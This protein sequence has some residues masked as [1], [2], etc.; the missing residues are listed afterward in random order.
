MPREGLDRTTARAASSGVVWWRNPTI[1]GVLAQALVVVLL[2]AVVWYLVHN[3][4]TNLNERSIRTG[5]SFLDQEAGFAIGESL[6]AFAP[7]DTYGRAL[8]V[9]LLNTLRVSIIGIVLATLIGVVVGIARLS[10]N[11]LVARLASVYVEVTRNIPLLLQLF[12]WYT[13]VTQLLPAVREALEPLPGVVLSKSGLQFPIIV[14]DPAHLP[15]LGV[16]ALSVVAAFV[17]RHRAYR[18]QLETGQEPR[19][20][21]PMLAIICLPALAVFLVTGA[22]LDLDV[23]EF[24]R[25][26]YRGGASVTPEF[27]ALLLGLSIY[28]AGFIAEIV[29]S[30]ILAVPWGQTEAAAALGFRRSLQ[31]R[32]IVLPQALRIIVPPTTSNYLNLTKNSSLAV[33]IGYPDLVSVGNTTLNQTGQAIECISIMMA[34]YLTISLLISAFMNWYNR[35]IALVER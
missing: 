19:L 10:S 3:T 15:V 27:L 16:L 13:I 35:R 14:G 26:N 25:F 20:L 28:T 4:L 34:I 7:T 1:R 12:F 6:I 32:L 31:L 30:G 8:L 29:R 23:P 11:W 17:Y 33:A 22:P 2:L 9:G 18:R 21:L 5:F 24:T